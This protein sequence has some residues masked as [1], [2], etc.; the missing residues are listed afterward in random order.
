MNIRT[1]TKLVTGIHHRRIRL[2][3]R[4]DGY[5]YAPGDPEVRPG[6]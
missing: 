5:S 4:G 3:Q 6:P 1:T 2:L